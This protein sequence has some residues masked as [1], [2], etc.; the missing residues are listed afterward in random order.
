LGFGDLQ[1]AKLN[2][3]AAEAIK[4]SEIEGERLNYDEVRSSIARKLGMETGGIPMG[5]RRSEGVSDIA[6]DASDHWREPLTS[7]R[8]FQWHKRLFP[9]GRGPYGRIRA[10]EWRDESSGQ[11][12][13]V[14]GD[15][16]YELVHF[17]APAANRVE[18]EMDKF[19]A[20]F[21]RGAERNGILRAAIAHLWFVTIH[22]FED[23]NGRV[24]RAVLDLALAQSDRRD[25]RCYSVSE[26][27]L[28]ERQA[29]YDAL[30]VTQGGTMDV[31]QWIE[32]LLGSL[33][34]ALETAIGRTAAVLS[35]AGFWHAHAEKNL[36]E[37][38]RKVLHRMLGDWEG[39]MTSQKWQKLTGA[40][41]KTATRDMVE[42]VEAGI[43][44]RDEGV[45]KNAAY[46]LLW[47]R[48][49]DI[50]DKV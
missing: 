19:L 1:E 18:G 38:Q 8:L 44:L 28:Q 22:P 40:S 42:L 25:W 47:D 50:V 2:A 4:S 45:R 43:F 10:G 48:S 13:V 33:A 49:G 15:I 24:G 27:I 32:W 20:W 16:G 3:M 26:Q 21:D 41:P 36:N 9:D 11:M 6:V 14:S 35:R 46:V 30:R 31:T 7:D 5:D 17:E 23:G 39:K 37:R 34:R 12:L 29:Y